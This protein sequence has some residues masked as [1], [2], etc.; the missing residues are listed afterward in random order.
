MLRVPWMVEFE[1]LKELF[2]Q[3][4]WKEIFL[5]RVVDHCDTE[6]FPEDEDIFEDAD[7]EE[8]IE[9]NTDF[10]ISRIMPNQTTEEELGLRS[11][12]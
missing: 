4:T 7:L 2:N 5:S 11:I 10:V 12:D 9:R 6:D 8:D 3:T 1:K